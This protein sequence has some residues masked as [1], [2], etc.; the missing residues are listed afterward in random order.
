MA[1]SGNH[2]LHIGASERITRE[3]DRR[4]V[5]ILRD[6]V[7]KARIRGEVLTVLG[8]DYERASHRSLWTLRRHLP[9]RLASLLLAHN[10]NAF[11]Q[12]AELGIGLTVSGHTH[13]GQITL[14][15]LGDEWSP[16]RF[17]SPYVRGRYELDGS[18]LY[19]SRG[20]GT[21]GIPVR[22]GAPPEITLLE[23]HRAE[24][25]ASGERLSQ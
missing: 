9:S 12:A 21:S 11:P 25:D 3:F 23:L 2:E 5:D 13:G 6:D 24:G 15:M 17:V 20:V 18:Q 19:V 7:R 4:G 8:V 14:E 22:L 1:V 16:A 10:P